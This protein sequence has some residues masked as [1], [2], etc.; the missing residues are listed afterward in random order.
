V[1]VV[2]DESGSGYETDSESEAGDLIHLVDNSTTMG[3]ACKEPKKITDKSSENET[4]VESN[5]N[6]SSNVTIL[7]DEDS[8]AVEDDQLPSL[9]S[10]CEAL[11]KDQVP[12]REK[13]KVQDTL[14]RGSD[15]SNFDSDH[16][17][18]SS[19]TSAELEDWVAV[20]DGSKEIGPPP[21]FT[22]AIVS[23]RS[24][25]HRAGDYQHL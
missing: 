24:R 3:I 9:R 22:L 16:Y 21:T 19:R 25:C 4:K 12:K 20:G 14:T 17:A 8:T 13:L 15:L 10:L 23:R 18:N 1:G 6:P 2:E 5:E 7:V 11:L